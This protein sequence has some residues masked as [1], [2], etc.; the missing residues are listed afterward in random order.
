[1]LLISASVVILT[2]HSTLNSLATPSASNPDAFLVGPGTAPPPS[3]TDQSYLLA[4]CRCTASHA[5]E[6]FAPAGPF[7]WSTYSL[8]PAWLTEQQFSMSQRT[9]RRFPV[10][11]NCLLS[12]WHQ[13]KLDLQISPLLVLFLLFG[14]FSP[15]SLEGSYSLW[16]CLGFN[17]R[18]SSHPITFRCS[19]Q[20]P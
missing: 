5:S 17:L 4:S 20:L 15:V 2:L 19:N 9:Q 6:S 7:I 8:P 12:P 1:M 13:I 18:F 10:S 11:W 3:P 16:C 14:G